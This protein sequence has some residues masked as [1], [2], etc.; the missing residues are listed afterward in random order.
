MKKIMRIGFFTDTYLPVIHGVEVSIETFRKELE[1]MGHQVFIFAPESP[2]YKDKNPK[3][4]RFK[5]QR[6]IEN[7][8]MYYA[9]AFL[10][11]SRNFK[12]IDHFKLDIVHAHTPFSLGLLAK[13]I[14]ERQIIPL[15]YTHHTHYPE[16]VKAYFGEELLLPYLA[17]I[18]STWF[19]NNSNA[20][21]AP[22]LK[23]KKLLQDYG[24][25]K[26]IQIHI[27]PT[28]INLKFFKKSVKNRQNLR[29][30]LKISPE[31]KILLSVSRIG[32]EKNIEFLIKAFHE[33]LKRRKDVLLLLV[34]DGPILEH[35][36]KI[37]QKLGIAP[38]IKFAGRIPSEEVPF[39]YQSSDV[40]LFASLTE[41]Q[42]IVILE[43]LGCGLPVV[44]LKDDAFSDV[45]LDGK[46]GF[47]IKKQSPKI[48]A[49]KITSILNNPTL[50]KKFSDSALKTAQKFSEKKVVEKLVE[51]YKTNI[52]KYYCQK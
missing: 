13:Y 37:S 14:S 29:K 21:I 35:L 38:F 48:F 24:V 43:A 46:N 7:P 36:K 9:F 6:L 30:K 16:Y 51:I 20:V 49:Q 4:F 39:Y 22:S 12:E 27:L 15:I 3:V 40:F 23:I 50:Y 41:T 52:D 47:L 45:V 1:A 33:L 25:K 34:G 32:K 42:G 8:E 31:T 5:S 44:A 11:V 18:Y 17:K 19:V 10:P 26:T 28:G 2:G